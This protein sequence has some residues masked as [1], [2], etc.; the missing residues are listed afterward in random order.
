MSSSPRSA[1][2]GLWRRIGARV[3]PPYLALLV[4][5]LLLLGLRAAFGLPLRALLAI[6]RGQLSVRYALVLMGLFA[7]ASLVSH[8]GELVRGDP[9]ARGRALRGAWAMVRDWLPFIVCLWVYENLHDLTGMIRPDTVDATLARADAAI[10]GVQPTLWLQRIQFPLLDDYM[11][12]AYMTYFL[13]PPL[14]AGWLY[15]RGHVI[16]FK[17][18]QLA[19]VVAFYVGFLG[20][21][22]VPAV[23]PQLILRDQYTVPLKGWLFYYRIKQVVL[24]L[25]DFPRDCFPSMHTA[26]SSVT[27]YFTWR[28]RRH[29][30]WRRLILPPVI[31]LTASLWFSTVYLRYHWFVDVLAGWGVTALACAVSVK[32]TRIW[33]TA[34][35]RIDEEPGNAGR[36]AS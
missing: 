17:E 18:F 27:L 11:A 4:F 24:R 30:P 15:L 34:E 9:G 28:H 32:L 20:Y 2:P 1:G 35:Q 5:G 7:L 21:I 6:T 14:L 26:I 23:G 31:I 36:Q 33:P 13:F 10:F 22:A 16:E 8:A 25:Q 3:P 12:L 29:L 19:M